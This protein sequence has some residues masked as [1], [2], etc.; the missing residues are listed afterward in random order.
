MARLQRKKATSGK[1]KKKQADHP[2]ASEGGK[3]GALPSKPA[4]GDAAV[5]SVRKQRPF[6]S[7][8]VAISKRA[9][10]GKIR[11]TID[12]SLQFLREVRVEL[13][14]VTWPSR[15][16]TMGSTGVVLVLVII[17]AAFLGLADI[18]LSSLIR[19]VL[20]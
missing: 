16:Q 19:V 10:P 1:K 17:I 4:P 9:E 11:G 13:K 18:A 6:V 20:Q 5:K 8:K 2:I 15:K 7:K 12:K 14:K 3:E